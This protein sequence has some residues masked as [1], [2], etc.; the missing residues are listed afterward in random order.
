M[1]LFFHYYLSALLAIVIA[2]LLGSFLLN[3]VVKLKSTNTYYDIFIKMCIGVATFT[4]VVSCFA[5]KGKTVLVLLLPYSFLGYFLYKQQ[6]SNL[7]QE[8]AFSTTSK[9]S[10]YVFT[11]VFA[12]LIFSLRYSMYSINN[13]ADYY[14]Y[15]R[16]SYKILA[17]GCENT[18]IHV[19]NGV[20]PY[21][22]FELWLNAGI[23]SVLGNNYYL[24]LMVVTFSLLT[25][26][27]WLGLCAIVE[28]LLPHKAIKAIL[29]SFLGLFI[30]GVFIKYYTYFPYLDTLPVFDFNIWAQPKTLI[31]YVVLIASIIHFIKYKYTTGILLFALLPLVYITT[32]P[33]VLSGLVIYMLVDKYVYKE[34]LNTTILYSVTYVVISVILFY[35]IFAER[36]N[37][38]TLNVVELFGSIKTK[39]NIVVVTLF[40]MFI[41][42]APLLLVLIVDFNWLKKII[43]GHKFVLLVPIVFVAALLSW[44]LF[45]ASP[46]NIQLFTNIAPP[47]INIFIFII[48]IYCFNETKKM[49]IAYTLLL[50][51]FMS[52]LAKDKYILNV[53]FNN[54]STTL[55]NRIKN[56]NHTSVSL[57]SRND[58]KTIFNKNTNVYFAGNY[59]TNSYSNAYS[60]NLSVHEIPIN[61]N[62]IHAKTEIKLVE[63]TPFYSYVANQ[64]KNSTF[65]TIQRSQLDFI[66]QNN[67]EY[68]ICDK[69]YLLPTHIQAIIND[70]IMYNNDKFLFIK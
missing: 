41:Y 40:Q 18:L 24:N 2:L 14:Y 59:L 9:N 12:T 69:N 29:F 36:T 68:I 45:P 3:Y 49:K 39:I 46:D 16:L 64:K 26:L 58:F 31:I 62:G 70:S 5:T 65:K 42:Y 15:A 37:A 43:T 8:V 27:V 19:T 20:A 67:V 53:D 60:I 28:I 32:A 10:K 21:H 50:I 54:S 23:S 55:I 52:A 34:K 51:V 17:T 4:I 66:T 7:V 1:L 33:S 63:N 25:L 22:Y 48:L 56:K 13:T 11:W 38:A 47:F 44:A 30:T 57:Q 35:I 61:S 6:E